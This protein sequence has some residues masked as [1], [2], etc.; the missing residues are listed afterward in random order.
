[1]RPGLEATRSRHCR[2]RRT[3]LRPDLLLRPARRGPGLH[4][5]D[6]LPARADG[7]RRPAG[8]PGRGSDG[9]DAPAHPPPRVGHALLR[10]HPPVD[11]PRRRRA[12]DRL[13]LGQGLVGALVGVGRADARLLP[14]HLPAVRGLPAAALLD[15]RPRAPGSLRV[16]VR[17]LG[18]GL[19][20]AQLCRG[21]HGRDLHPPTGVLADRRQHAARD[22]PHLPGRAGRH[23]A[24]LRDAVDARARLEERRGAAAPRPA[25][26]SA[27]GRRSRSG[28]RRRG[29]SPA[30]GRRGARGGLRLGGERSHSGAAL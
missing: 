10:G 26:P 28:A 30:P 17:D 11:H 3:R 20:R 12:R 24:G 16:G 23:G 27:R 14:D 25:A 15:R 1:V 7:H 29:R 2:R 5:E 21:A 22:V 8:L 19:H 13:D 4:P 18:G 9:G 6:L